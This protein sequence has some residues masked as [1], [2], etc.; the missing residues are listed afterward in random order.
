M[1]YLLQGGLGMPD[2]DYY[3]SNDPHMVELRAPYKAHIAA[4]M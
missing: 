1:P 4:I 3:T 2:R